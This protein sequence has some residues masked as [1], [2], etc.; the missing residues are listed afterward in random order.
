MGIIGE[1]IHKTSE[2][3]PINGEEIPFSSEIILRM[4]KAERN[5]RLRL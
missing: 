1:E 3:I 4:K 2:E 5:A